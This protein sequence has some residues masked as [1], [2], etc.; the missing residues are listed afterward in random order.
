MLALLALAVPAV[1]QE[2]L[3]IL[4]APLTVGNFIAL[5]RNPYFA[6]R[7]GVKPGDND[8][9]VSGWMM[10]ALKSAKMINEDAAGR[11]DVDAMTRL[12]Q[13]LL[14]RRVQHPRVAAPRGERGGP[15]QSG[16]VGEGEEA[17]RRLEEFVPPGRRCPLQLVDEPEPR[18]ALDLR[19]RDRQLARDAEGPS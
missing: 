18:H 11:G 1:A 16:G 10:M 4:D 12:G 2:S 9:S 3:A 19:H 13:A 5:A 17:G 6:W 14:D 8:T 7:Y 15:A